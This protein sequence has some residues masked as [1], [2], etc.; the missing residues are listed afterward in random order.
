[1]TDHTTLTM[2]REKVRIR[3]KEM[4]K[5]MLDLTQVAVVGLHDEPYPYCV[6]MN[7]GYE[8]EGDLPVFY[9]HMA[10][11]G[12]RIELIKKDPRVC[13]SIS[14]FLDRHGFASY[15]NETHDYR[16][17]TVFGTAEIIKPED[18][19][20]SYLHAFSVLCRCNSGRPEVKQA[21]PEMLARLWALRVT[22]EIVTGKTQYP[23][24]SVE[25]VPM[26]ANQPRA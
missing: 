9:F 19:M 22:A 10:I 25:E 23:I 14:T 15:R 8:W 1:M 16:S 18:D 3:D 11:E 12:H 7:F 21:S 17:V 13:L 20:D 5:A 26:P 24:S 4:L 6:P 2:H